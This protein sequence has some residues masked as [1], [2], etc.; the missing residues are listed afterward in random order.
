[1]QLGSSSS[2]HNSVKCIFLDR[3]AFVSHFCPIPFRS[4]LIP[5]RPAPKIWLAGSISGTKS[6]GHKKND[7]LPEGREAN[8]LWPCTEWW[9]SLSKCSSRYDLHIAGMAGNNL[10]SVSKDFLNRDQTIR[11]QRRLH[12][13]NMECRERAASGCVAWHCAKKFRGHCAHLASP[14]SLFLL[15]PSAVSGKRIRAVCCARSLR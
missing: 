14:F 11:S 15:P 2:D 5:R 6:A 8:Q 13:N 1:M 9:K 3:S 4:L 12:R 10:S 7:Q